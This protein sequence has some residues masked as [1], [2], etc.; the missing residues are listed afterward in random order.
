MARVLPWLERHRDV[1]FFAMIHVADP[2]SPYFAYEPYDEL[3]GD[4]G[5]ADAHRAALEQ[6]RPHIAHPLMKAFGMPLRSEIVA[7]G[8]DPEP[9]VER[10][11]D[12]YDGSIRGLDV[13]VGRLLEQLDY[14]GLR[15]QVVVAFVSDHGTEFLDHDAHFHGHSA[16]G[17]LNR[18]PLFF[19]GPR[20]VPAGIEIPGT[21]QTI[22]LAPT[23]LELAGLEKPAAMQGRSL[24]PYLRAGAP[25]PEPL[26]AFT[27]KAVIQGAGGALPGRNFAS[28][29]VV[30]EGWKLIW[31][32]EAPA[33]IP[34]YELFDHAADPLNL[35]D[36]AA[37]HQDHVS[38]LR[39]VIE[40]W[41]EAA[42]AARLDPA[43]TEGM[44][45]EE[46][47][48]LRALGYVQ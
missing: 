4:P 13:E 45:A 8:V 22:D 25:A 9:F 2:H 12:A 3:W 43:S 35:V 6:V 30:S 11:L 20:F 24:A 26:P 28:L 36:V 40:K 18:V 39:G 29:A 46:L 27:E 7:S 41:Q 32:R 38:R 42:L 15:D 33:G 47:E 34:E 31:N 37:D 10:E 23:V 48:R 21:V 44:S 5:D 16:Y 1:P 19:W 14:L 17:E